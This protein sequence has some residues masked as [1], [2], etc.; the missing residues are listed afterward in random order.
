MLTNIVSIVVVLR[1]V[2]KDY[3]MLMIFNL[4]FGLKRVFVQIKA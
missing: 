4:T 2:V 1:L 3:D